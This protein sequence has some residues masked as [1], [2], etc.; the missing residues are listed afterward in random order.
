MAGHYL[1]LEVADVYE[2]VHGLVIFLTDVVG[3][4]VAEDVSHTGDTRDAVL[5]STGEPEVPNGLPRYIRIRNE[6]S[7]IWLHTYETFVSTTVNTGEVSDATYGYVNSFAG[8]AQ[9]F[10]MLVVADLERVIINNFPYAGINVYT[11]YVGRITS[12]HHAG[13]H[14]YPNLVKVAW[15]TIAT[16][17]YSGTERNCFMIG[18][19]GSKQH[20]FAVEPLNSI[21]LLAGDSSDRD[22]TATL[23]APVLVNTD[24]DTQRSELVGEPRG[25]YRISPEVSQTNAFLTI[26]GEVYTTFVQ[27]GAHMVMGPIG[28]EIPPLVSPVPTDGVSRVARRETSTTAHWDETTIQSVSGTV[29]GWVDKSGNGWDLV[30]GTTAPLHLTAN[31]NGLDTIDCKSTGGY[32]DLTVSG[33]AP[34]SGSEPGTFYMVLIT[35]SVPGVRGDSPLDVTDGSF[36]TLHPWTE[37][38]IYSDFGSTTRRNFL[39]NPDSVVHG[40]HVFSGVSAT[41]NHK[42]DING[43]LQHSAGT[44]TV[45]WR[46]TGAAPWVVGGGETGPY[47]GRIGEVRLYAAEHDDETRLYITQVLKDKWGIL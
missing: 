6:D 40:W 24:A 1:R 30:P 45:S 28:T 34:M 19:H 5:T 41:S 2:A 9:G 16:W 38:R 26:D 22:G 27:S 18:P 29:T 4:V 31:Q 32:M 47:K 35:D 8:G 42:F 17:Y 33:G 3:W 21:G 20:Y 15:S 10:E 7:K 25:V 44:N 23:A 12:Y 37:T 36:G 46:P 43:I 14:S 39:Q 13:D 11:G